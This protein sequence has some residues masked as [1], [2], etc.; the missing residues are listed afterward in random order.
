MCVPC[1]QHGDHASHGYFTDLV[2]SGG[3]GC[4]KCGDIIAWKEFGFCSRHCGPG[5]GAPLPL[6]T[7]ESA[8][9]VMEALLYHW[10]H[11]LRVG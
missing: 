6:F 1:F 3:V 5:K 4:C 11:R 9:S 7:V 2:A 10:V 8:S